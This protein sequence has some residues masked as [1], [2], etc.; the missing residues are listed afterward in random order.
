MKTTLTLFAAIIAVNLLGMGC[1][2]S[3]GYE[4]AGTWKNKML[5]LN[6]GIDA[7][8]RGEQTIYYF[9]E[10]G[11][12]ILSAPH[13][14]G[15]RQGKWH[16]VG[17]K[18]HVEYHE[19]VLP[20]GKPDLSSTKSGFTLRSVG[21]FYFFERAAGKFELQIPPNEYQL[22]VPKGYSGSLVF[23]IDQPDVRFSVEDR[24][25]IESLGIQSGRLRK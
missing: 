15:E 11:T 1:A 19:R 17:N 20:N 13:L 23:G 6:E 4:Q 8:P 14:F 24:E 7:P 16:D 25:N 12:L 5:V 18:R 3:G 21:E 9:Q 10:G 2:R 22:L